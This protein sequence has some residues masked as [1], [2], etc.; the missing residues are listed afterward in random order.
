MMR[1]FTFRIRTPCVCLTWPG[2]VSCHVAP[3][4]V[5]SHPSQLQPQITQRSSQSSSRDLEVS[6]KDVYYNEGCSSSRRGGAIGV[7]RL[8]SKVPLHRMRHLAHI[9]NPNPDCWVSILRKAA[10]NFGWGPVQVAQ[11]AC[12]ICCI[13]TVQGWHFEA[14][15]ESCRVGEAR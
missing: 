14:W 11:E 4:A 3:G 7:G 9:Q 2:P 6:V 12:T 10:S 5:K 13:C 1:L 15:L 8:F